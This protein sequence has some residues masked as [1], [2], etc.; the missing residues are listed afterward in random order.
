MRKIIANQTILY[1]HDG[2]LHTSCFGGCSGCT[3]NI[4]LQAGDVIE[5]TRGI[6]VGRVK[7]FPYDKFIFAHKLTVID[8]C[9]LRGWGEIKFSIEELPEQ[10]ELPL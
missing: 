10:L 8:N 7:G 6:S 5:S 3:N 4:K 2:V 1:I 9:L